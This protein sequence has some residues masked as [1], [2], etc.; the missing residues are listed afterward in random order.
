MVPPLTDDETYLTGENRDRSDKRIGDIGSSK[1][2]TTTA[3]DSKISSVV[4]QIS[5]SHIQIY[6]D[7][8][9]DIDEYKRLEKSLNKYSATVEEYNNGTRLDIKKKRQ[10]WQMIV[11]NA[12]QE[13]ECNQEFVPQNRDVIKQ[14]LVGFGMRITGCHQGNTTMSFL[15]TTK[16]S[17]GVQMVVTA[18]SENS[19]ISKDA[20]SFHH[21][22]AGKSCYTIFFVSIVM[23]WQ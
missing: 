13:T 19:A 10:L 23:F 15:L 21:F 6:V 9:D 4:S 8:V 18:K 3:V 22:D 20:T 11:D 2:N 17:S 14:L 12:T 5:F 1:I 16:D 7:H